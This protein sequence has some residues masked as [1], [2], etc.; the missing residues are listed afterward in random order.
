MQD[1]INVTGSWER[2]YQT[3]FRLSNIALTSLLIDGLCANGHA[4]QG[5]FTPPCVSPASWINEYRWQTTP[6]NPVI[7]FMQREVATLPVV[8][9]QSCFFEPFRKSRLSAGCVGRLR[10]VWGCPTLPYLTYPTLLER[11]MIW[12]RVCGIRKGWWVGKVVCLGTFFFGGGTSPE[13][14]KPFPYFRP[15]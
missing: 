3:G 2:H 12:P 7:H 9:S 13:S 5:G 8:S 15:K 1:F 10:S 11:W 6:D 14:L 4:V